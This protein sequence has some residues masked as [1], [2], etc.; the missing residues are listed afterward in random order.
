[1]TQ[2]QLIV[3]TRKNL[4]IFA[5][6]HSITAACKAFGISKTTYYKI[7][8]DFIKTGSLEPKKR[9]KPRMPNETTLSVKKLL[10]RIVKE[11]PARGTQFYAYELRNKESIAL[12]K[13]FGFA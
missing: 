3:N 11:H 7:R 13:R 6:R 2:Q 10:L 5:Q 8:N 4:L 12:S 1:M 9:R